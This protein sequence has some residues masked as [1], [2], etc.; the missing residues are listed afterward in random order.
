MTADRT[1]EERERARLEREAR[2]AAREGRPPPAPP[3][4]PPAQREAR[5]APEQPA[6]HDP[7]PPARAEPEAQA[8]LEPEDPAAVEPEDPAAAEPEHGRT[9]TEVRPPE[10]PP[11]FEPLGSGRRSRPAAS[12]SPRAGRSAAERRAAATEFLRSDGRAARSARAPASGERG[13]RSRSIVAAAVGGLVVLVSAWFLLSL[14]QPFKGDGSGQV[15]VTIPRGAGVG[16]IAALLEREGVISSAFFFR[17]RTKLAGA[18][19][20]FK[21]GTIPMRRD[22]SY[23]AAIDTLSDPPVPDTVTITIPEGLSRSETK[24]L[25]GDSLRGDYLTASR[26]SRAL[27]PR[28]YGARNATSLEGFLF[29]ATYELKPNQPVGELVTRQLVAFKRTLAGVD[30]RFA[31][32]KNLTVYDV[33]TIA[34]MVDR[35]AQLPRERRLVA[36]VIYNRLSQGIPLGIDATIRFATGNWSEPLKQS[37]LAIDS[38]YNTRTHQ[39]LPPGPIGNPGLAAIEAAAHPA[40]T[41]YLYYVVKPNACGEHSFSETDAEFQADVER[42]NSERAARGGKSPTDC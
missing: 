33:L 15:D 16:D 2:R 20:D 34:S 12:R 21:A 3:A 4:A 27:Q 23:S 6:A 10:P 42:Y 36:S 31:K 7:E 1:P 26:R 24:D 11:P 37:E 40:K 29:P 19:G 28:D 14:F 32:S 17:T 9:A 5:P 13:G 22:M 25:V 39:G 35:E 38:G 18:D 30:L 8:S 41:D